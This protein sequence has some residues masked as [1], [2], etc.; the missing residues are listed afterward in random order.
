MGHV[1]LRLHPTKLTLYL[2]TLLVLCLYLLLL[3][4]CIPSF[5]NFYANNLNEDWS[6]PCANTG[7][8]SSVLHNS[9]LLPLCVMNL[10][11]MGGCGALIR[12]KHTGL[13]S[14]LGIII[15]L[16]GGITRI[17]PLWLHPL[18]SRIMWSR[19]KGRGGGA[20]EG[21]NWFTCYIPFHYFGSL[22]GVFFF[23]TIIS[24]RGYTAW[25]QTGCSS[26]I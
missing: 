17:F 23:I 18:K 26:S 24:C 9:L 13:R 12:L 7:K 19:G 3:I 21:F 10:L 4:L 8:E 20:R 16:G 11:F 2:S 15:G 22:K 5:N 6:W 1:A 25:I 14:H